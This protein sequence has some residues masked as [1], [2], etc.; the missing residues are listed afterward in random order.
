MIRAV[1]ALAN[2]GAQS[3][4]GDLR[5]VRQSRHSLN[6]NKRAYNEDM[7][8]IW[9]AQHTALSSKDDIPDDDDDDDEDML[10]LLADLE[11]DPQ[12]GGIK[13][14]GADGSAA[15]TPSAGTADGAAAAPATPSAATTGS[16]QPASPAKGPQI[17]RLRIQR[18]IQT[19]DG[20]VETEVEDIT[21]PHV[22]QAYLAAR[23]RIPQKKAPSSRP[24]PA[25]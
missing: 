15:A 20:Q 4:E 21:D 19:E 11:E 16:S 8:R 5:Y 23:E 25:P 12:G 13:S 3:G 7:Q 1:R 18:K 24:R 10:D 17:K 14:G 2:S 6:E 22:I 9:N